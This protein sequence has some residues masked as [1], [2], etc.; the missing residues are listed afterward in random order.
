MS[1]SI[2]SSG[3]D[4]KITPP[5]YEASTVNRPMKKRALEGCEIEVQVE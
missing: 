2:C 3:L 1:Q 5:E 4:L